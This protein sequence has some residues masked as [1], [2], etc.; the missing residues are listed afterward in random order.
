MCLLTVCTDGNVTTAVFYIL[1]ELHIHDHSTN[2]GQ[3]GAVDGLHCQVQ[4][5]VCCRFLEGGHLNP[6]WVDQEVPGMSAVVDTGNPVGHFRFNLVLIGWIA[7][8]HDRVKGT[9]SRDFLLLVFLMNQF[10]PSP[11]VLH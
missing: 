6:M 3:Q 10:P 5:V 4:V 1:T 11:R 2:A 8:R 9:V 7:A